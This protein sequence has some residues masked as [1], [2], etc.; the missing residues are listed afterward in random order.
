MNNDS[1]TTRQE[2][3]H[4]RI[5]RLLDQNPSASQRDIAVALGVSLGGVNYCLRALVAKGH[6]KI[7]NFQA[8]KNKL[9]YV[10]VLTPE[11]IAH[12]AKLA[13]RFIRRKMAEYEAIKA[14]IESL[15]QDYG[16]K[17]AT[18]GDGSPDQSHTKPLKEP[19]DSWRSERS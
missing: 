2:D 16:D 3:I 4:F 12:R 17:L 8:S 18:A 15:R 7:E 13:A 19:K 10:Y 14:E 11:G 9:R 1:D 5:L 6:V